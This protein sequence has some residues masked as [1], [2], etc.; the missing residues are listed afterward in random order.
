[1]VSLVS[2]VLAKRLAKAKTK[3]RIQGQ[4]KSSFTSMPGTVQRS[5]GVV[6]I[7]RTVMES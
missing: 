2:S 1:V 3:A 5:F 4:G 7:S 6:I